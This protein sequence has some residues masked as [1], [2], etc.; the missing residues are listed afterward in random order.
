[1]IG[2]VVFGAAL[3]YLLISIVVVL[4]AIRYAR[5]NGKSAKSW[6]R[7]AAFVMYSLVLWDWLQTVATQEFYCAKDSGFT[8]H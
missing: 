6:G 3:L 7:G 4:W 2:L 8:K 1:M 5:G